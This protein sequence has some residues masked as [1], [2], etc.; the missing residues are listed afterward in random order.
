MVDDLCFED[1]LYTPITCFDAPSPWFYHSDDKTKNMLDSG[2][3]MIFYVFYDA[4]MMEILCCAVILIRPCIDMHERNAVFDAFITRCARN[5][6]THS[7]IFMNEKSIFC[8]VEIHW[9]APKNYYFCLWFCDGFLCAPKKKERYCP[10]GYWV[11]TFWK[12]RIRSTRTGK[13]LFILVV[14]V[15]YLQSTGGGFFFTFFS[16]SHANLKKAQWWG[17]VV[18]RSLL[19]ELGLELA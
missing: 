17:R 15:L 7:F 6:Y 10:H 5:L 3:I 8:D 18:S 14:S 11:C 19:P 9:Y 1:K 12:T 16:S 13:D 4:V 2:P